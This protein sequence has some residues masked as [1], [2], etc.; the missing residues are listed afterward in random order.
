MQ[1]LSAQTI[2]QLWE[3]GQRQHA[4]ERMVTLLAAALPGV[5][6]ADLL[7]LSV[8]QRDA[9]LLMLREYTFGP[10]FAGYAVCPRCAE[11]IECS[12][13]ISDIWS[14]A[15]PLEESGRARQMQIGEYELAVSLPTQADVLA[16]AAMPT[17][18]VTEARSFLLQRC[19]RQA[20]RHGETLDVLALPD[21]IVR[22]IGERI[23]ND[24][25]QAE[26][27]LM[28]D[29]P[30]CEHLWSV[31]FDC[32]TFLWAEIATQ[33]KRLLR[34]VHTLALAYGWSEADILAMS[35][36]RRQSYLEMVS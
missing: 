1:G 13:M 31:F 14:G 23:S 21:E 33:A 30:A 15:A 28:V 27:Q 20:M 3:R 10:Q 12:F 19:V 29:C 7:S 11:R 18:G 24:D 6:H 2:V 32:A 17:I 22:A 25:P 4:A 36:I 26:V 16:I 5:A 34:E 8:G 35:T 9:Y